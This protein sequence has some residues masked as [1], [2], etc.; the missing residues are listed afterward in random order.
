MSIGYLIAA[1]IC[2][3]LG[4]WLCQKYA[5][6]TEL[7][8]LIFAAIIWGPGCAFIWSQ[9][10][11]SHTWLGILTYYTPVSCI[12]FGLMGVFVMGE[13]M[14][15]RMWGAVLLAIASVYLSTSK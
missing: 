14:T 9:I 3:L 7:G 13:Q 10:F 12:A 15:S 8:Y 6:T 1:G 5:D 11:K 2:G 4:D